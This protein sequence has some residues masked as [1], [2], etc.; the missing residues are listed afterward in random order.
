MFGKTQAGKS[1]FIEF[2]KNYASQHCLIDESLIGNGF[3][4]KTEDP[5]QFAVHTNLPV[6]EVFDSNG[7]W[8]DIR[9]LGDQYDDSSDYLDAI[10]DK[11][12]TLRPVPHNPDTSQD[13]VEITFLDTPGIEDTSGRD[14]DNAPKIIKAMARMQTLNLIIVI[15]NCEDAPSKPHQLAFNYYSK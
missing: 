11:M 14:V 5:I 6:Y 2:V 13:F 10:R 3:W 4:S 9:T 1:T 15:I 12:A 8:I 7:T